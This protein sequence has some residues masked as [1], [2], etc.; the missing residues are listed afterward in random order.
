[1][2]WPK[3]RESAP[4]K[5]AAG[6][7]QPSVSE[8]IQNYLKT[9]QEQIRWKRARPVLAL[10]LERHLEDQ[11]DAFIR[12]G[13]SADEA[14]RLA[15]ADMGDPVE[16]GAELDRVHRP[17]PQW[18]LLG[19][20]FALACVCTTLRLVLTAGWRFEGEELPLALLS[21]LLGTGCMTGTYL[22]DISR[23]ARHAAA[24]CIGIVSL[25]AGCI[26]V[27]ANLMR[28]SMP[29]Y[30]FSYYLTLFL[31][32]VYALW[33]YACR[34]KGWPGLFAAIAGGIP[35][36]FVSAWWYPSISSLAV[37]VFSGF[38]LVLCA[39]WGDG[40]GVRRGSGTAAV[41]GVSALLGWAVWMLEL[42]HMNRLNII[43]HPE[44]DPQGAG[45][46]ALYVREF[47]QEIPLLRSSTEGAGT[48]TGSRIQLPGGISVEESLG[49]DFLPAAMAARWGWLP[50][51]L[52]LAATAALVLWLVVRA[53]RQKN[54]LGR[55]VALSAALS[56]GFRAVL[57]MALNLGILIFGTGFPMLGGN[58]FLVVDMALIGL[59]LSAFRG[60]SIAREEAYP[61]PPRRRIKRIRLNIEYQ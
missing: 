48:N 40:F 27:N 31:P 19:L 29:L 58:S 59:A 24:I 12:E 33:V 25:G 47:V 14:E 6:P 43:L 4:P 35:M 7:A 36:L 3:R 2:A 50:L 30:R 56:L 21:L 52:L 26:L 22:L 57:S 5:S 8:P 1:M 38:G 37:L 20:T 23:L 11:R 61:F 44:Q 32:I 13:K 9:V 17:R 46:F 55:L 39:A 45:W 16:T 10:E 42:R 53:L 34:G 49:R 54:R 18:G 60:E 41:L 51:L 28:P 15:I